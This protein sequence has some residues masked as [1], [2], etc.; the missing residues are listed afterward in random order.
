VLPFLYVRLV[1]S[2]STGLILVLVA[3]DLP[4]DLLFTA[5]VVPGAPDGVALAER[6]IKYVQTC[7]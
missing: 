4:I 6:R 2:R 5:I 3:Q 7:G 1:A